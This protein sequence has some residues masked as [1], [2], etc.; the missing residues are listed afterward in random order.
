MKTKSK[1]RA[2]SE[3]AYLTLKVDGTQ[4]KGGVQEKATRQ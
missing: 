4:V 1:I 3:V 2:G